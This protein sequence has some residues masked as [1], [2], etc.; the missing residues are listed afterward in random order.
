MDRTTAPQPRFANEFQPGIA[1]CKLLHSLAPPAPGEPIF[2]RLLM[3][4]ADGTSYM[5]AE[6]TEAGAE[7]ITNI[8]ETAENQQ[9][10]AQHPGTWRLSLVRRNGD[11]P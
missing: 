4:T 6:L 2:L 10:A 1:L 5:A 3:Q 9:R 8:L 11:A 7:R